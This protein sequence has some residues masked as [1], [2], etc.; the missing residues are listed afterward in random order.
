M[1]TQLLAREELNVFYID[2]FEMSWY[3]IIKI[4]HLE[5]FIETK[6]QS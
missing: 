5:K 4:H 6:L 3:I 1:Y 2:T